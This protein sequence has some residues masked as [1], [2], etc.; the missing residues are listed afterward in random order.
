MCVHVR[1]IKIMKIY[2][3]F[4]FCSQ[5]KR[6]QMA[7]HGKT[8][9]LKVKNEKEKT[10]V[11]RKMFFNFTTRCCISK[12]E[13]GLFLSINFL[14]ALLCLTFQFYIILIIF[15]IVAVVK[16]SARKYSYF[17]LIFPI[18]CLLSFHLL[19]YFHWKIAFSVLCCVL[20]VAMLLK[21]IDKTFNWCDACENWNA[22]FPFSLLFE[23]GFQIVSLFS[24]SFYLLFFFFFVCNLNWIYFW[25]A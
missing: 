13:P 7:C 6:N 21:Q 11:R 3:F 4:P 8:A 24:L 10:L 25:V 2:Y 15:S 17:S 1:W 23:F 12:P 9:A 20:M 18:F 22:N 5:H 16:W 14:Y 19:V